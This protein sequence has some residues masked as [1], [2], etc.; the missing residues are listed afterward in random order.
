MTKR[1][2]TKEKASTNKQLAARNILHANTP[3][4]TDVHKIMHPCVSE[5]LKVIPANILVCSCFHLKLAK[6]FKYR[7]K[8][9]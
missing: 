6:Q 3:M 5:V 2:S 8:H 7:T 1:K 4:Q 9:L